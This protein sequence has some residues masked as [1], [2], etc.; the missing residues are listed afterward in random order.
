MTGKQLMAEIL[1]L[2]SI[3]RQIEYFGAVP[4]FDHVV[5]DEFFDE[6]IAMQLSEEFPDFESEAW[7]KYDNAIEVKKTCNN[8]NLFPKNSYHI[9]SFLNSDEFAKYLSGKIFSGKKLYSDP[10][11]NGGGWHIHKKGGKLNTHLD[12]SLHP[13]LPLQR[14]FNIIIYMNPNWRSD[15]GGA[16]GLWSGESSERPGSLAKTIDCKFNRAV[17][18]DTTQNSWHGLPDPIK[19]P[20]NE[21]RKSIAV[22][23]LCD[24][25]FNIDTRGKALF[26]PTKEQEDDHDVLQL[27][28]D[29][30]SI[31]RASSTYTNK[32]ND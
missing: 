10:G 15:W 18:F 13:K 30:A 17:I 16:L 4:P 23:Y 12:Y 22:Y 20:S 9:F 11:L 24:P 29:R 27:I 32:K 6:S 31:S 2:D 28:K 1:N 5:I 3:E 19:C 8:W 7:H 21:A 26:A 25:S 14:K